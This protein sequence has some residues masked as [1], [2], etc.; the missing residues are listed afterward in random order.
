[1]KFLPQL[2][3]WA[4]A[5]VASA[6][7][8]SFC[9]QAAAAR[10]P[11]IV[12]ILA[13]DLGYMDIGANNPKTFYETPNLNRLASQGV[14]FTDGY[15]ACPVCSPTRAS[16]LTGKYPAR[17]Q[18]TDYIGGRRTGKLLPAE[19]LDHLPLEEVTLA[20]ALKEAGYTTGFFG[21]WHLGTGQ[22]LT[23]AQ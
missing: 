22:Y 5:A 9:N 6:L 4:V 7:L 3:T 13:D 8:L 19:Y 1:M 11:N 21:K 16:I 18:L 15:A 2:K 14:R 10:K 20:E 12:F 23:E 17:L